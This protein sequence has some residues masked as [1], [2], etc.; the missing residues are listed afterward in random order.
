MEVKNKGVEFDI[1]DG[2]GVHLGDLIITKS[3]LIWCEGR[4]SR[5]NGKEISWEE[6]QGFMN[7]R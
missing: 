7:S 3:K 1:Y 4:V 2:N 5:K 6:F